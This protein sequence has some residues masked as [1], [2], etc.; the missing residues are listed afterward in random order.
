MLKR[1]HLYP[2]GLHTTNIDWPGLFTT[3]LEST[4]CHR[5]RDLYTKLV[6]G[7]TRLCDWIR[8]SRVAT[9]SRRRR[10]YHPFDVIGLDLTFQKFHQV[11]CVEQCCRIGS[12][13]TLVS[14]LNNTAT[15]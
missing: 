6:S 14:T 15:Q 10:N 3:L 7:G 11:L 13:F 9:R 12:L 2:G 8:R 1:L 5:V 4:R